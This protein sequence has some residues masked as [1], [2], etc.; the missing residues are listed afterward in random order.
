M[1]CLLEIGFIGVGRC[2]IKRKQKIRAKENLGILVK[3]VRPGH[4]LPITASLPE[5]LNCSQ[6]KLD[7]P[8]FSR[9]STGGCG[10]FW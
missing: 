4:Q 6:I 2:V 5:N 7:G 9:E 1:V 3:I 8:K 10:I